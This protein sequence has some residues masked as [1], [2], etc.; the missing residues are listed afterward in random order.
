MRY[1][2]F[3]EGSIYMRNPIYA[4]TF[5]IKSMFLQIYI[6]PQLVL[7]LTDSL[8]KFQF[9]KKSIFYSENYNLL[10]IF[11]VMYFNFF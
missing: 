8:L 6:G 5:D 4:Y 1:E 11:R 7:I 10:Y 2:N 3:F 9:F